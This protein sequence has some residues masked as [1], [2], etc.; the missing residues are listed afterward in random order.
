MDFKPRNKEIEKL[1][2]NLM[3]YPVIKVKPSVAQS[4]SRYDKIRFLSSK[5]N[6]YI[7]KGVIGIPKN[8]C[9]KKKK[10]GCFDIEFKI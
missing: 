4:L 3:N 5:N 1:M 8:V 7:Q 6:I 10:D 2:E 9:I